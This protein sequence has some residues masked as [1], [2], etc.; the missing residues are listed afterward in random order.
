[1]PPQLVGG[2]IWTGMVP[3][4]EILA[5]L[6]GLPAPLKSFVPTER[7]LFGPRRVEKRLGLR[8]EVGK[9]PAPTE[10]GTHGASHDL[11]CPQRHTDGVTPMAWSWLLIICSCD[12]SLQEPSQSLPPRTSPRSA[13]AS[14]TSPSERTLQTADTRKSNSQLHVM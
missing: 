1:M 12:G 11:I 6:R 3:Q 5:C 13:P 8:A 9:A 2:T 14:P 4:E 7:F 10:V